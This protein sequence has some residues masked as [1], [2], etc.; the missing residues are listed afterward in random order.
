MANP[1][2]MNHYVQTHPSTSTHSE[3]FIWI[4]SYR[5][6]IR[7][8]KLQAISCNADGSPLLFWDAWWHPR[9]LPVH[10]DSVGFPKNPIK[11]AL[12]LLLNPLQVL[13]A[14]KALGVKLVDIS[15]SRRPRGE[16][17]VLGH[18]FQPA[19]RVRASPAPS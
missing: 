7:R 14:E 17:T 6:K 1:G 9:S 4:Q 12:S 2:R 8:I 19:D 10:H 15:R 3:S 11:H 5:T 18:D 13:S 16:P